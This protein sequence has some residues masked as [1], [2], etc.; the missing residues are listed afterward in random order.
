M[1]RR[2]RSASLW[3]FR[4]LFA[5]LLLTLLPKG[6]AE[7]MRLGLLGPHPLYAVTGEEEPLAQ[8]RGFVQWLF[9]WTRPLPRTAD[10]RPVPYTDLPPFGV[11]VFLEQEADPAV[12]ERTVR[13]AAEAGFHWIRQEF[14][15][16]DIE[17]HGKGDF[18][19]RRHVPYRSAWEKYDEI[20]ALAEAYDLE[21]IARLSNPPA[22]SRAA[23]DAN[24]TYAP[25]DDFDDYGDFVA[26]VAERY[27]GRIRFYQIWNE[28][29]IYPEWGNQPVDPVA[30]T[31][32]LCLAYR[33]IKA[34]DPQAVI[35]TGALA[36]TDQLGT[37]IAEGGN[38]LMDTLF[39]QR[40]Y[41]AGAKDCFDILAVNDYML[42]SGPTDHRLRPQLVNF[43]RPMWVRDVMVANGDA[44]KPIWITEMN[45]NAVPEGMPAPYGRVG[46]AQQARYAVEA[47][48]R[49]QREWPW[50]GVVD[51]WF[52]RRPSEA[53]RDQ[54]WY[55]FR[56]MEP[57]F[58]PL[59]IYEALRDY[60]TTLEPTL[61][62][63]VH[64]AGSWQITYS[65]GWQ[66][67]EEATSRV[68][69]VGAALSLRWEGRSLVL[70]GRLERGGRL[71]Y[72]VDGGEARCSTSGTV[73]VAG[74]F[75][76]DA[77]TLS[78]TV[79]AGTLTLEWVEVR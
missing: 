69:G 25:P 49:I 3:A 67:G 77:H 14:P 27:K 16:E 72:A 19:D 65:E 30:Y 39:L 79:E 60:L 41:D 63:G 20:V 23:G 54:P 24:G 55:Y 4:L 11:N 22:W 52:L 48:E 43:S 50:V 13:A 78:L 34:V 62:R 76:P 58:T 29:N 45:S 44:A 26:T 6:L 10:D 53:E 12:R 66:A 75:L 36:P 1:S 70:H 7:G 15:W 59:P 64:A 8:L 21:I 68:G 31:R 38:N 40:M 37:P 5:A 57:D 73:E 71:C 18:E 33:R 32:L 61:Y 42:R 2:S 46:E 74:G 17:I 28:P 35:I 9:N 51:F 47:L 56:L